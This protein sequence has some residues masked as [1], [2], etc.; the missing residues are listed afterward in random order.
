M[1]HIKV[2]GSAAGGG[3]PQ[4]N[5]NCNNCSGFRAGNLKAKARTQSSIAVSE[6]GISWVLINASPDIRE[7][8]HLHKEFHPR[9]GN[10][11]SPIQA[12]V[13]VDA[14]I[15][16]SSGL[17]NLR[18]GNRLPIYTTKAVYEDLTT[19]YPILSMLDHYCKIDHYPLDVTSD[20][21]IP[22][23]A[24]LSFKPVVLHGK[25]PPYSPHRQNPQVGDNIG[26]F[27]T[28]KQSGKSLFYAPALETIPNKVQA[29]MS[30]VDCL[31]V[32][33]TFWTEDEMLTQGVG[34]KRSAEMGHM[35]LSGDNG[36][37]AMLEQFTKPR[38]VLIHI[39]NTNPILNEESP[40]HGKVLAKGI[41]IAFDGMELTLT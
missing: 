10:R 18:E 14:Q 17:I 5:C 9:S 38:K 21:E 28:D 37:L 13:L 31:M 23:F 25:A 27:I 41:E 34:S 11:D 20:F 6:D 32:D 35:P 39:N 1:L 26:L 40:E 22:N 4:W 7:Q 33:G 36:I 3:F 8:L 30:D 15:D 24:N 19:G 2:L 16:H 29:L 12:V